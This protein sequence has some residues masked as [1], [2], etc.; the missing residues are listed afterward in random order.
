MGKGAKLG[1]MAVLMGFIGL[2]FFAALAREGEAPIA[3]LSP[4]EL[5]ALERE[6]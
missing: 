2:L 4:S 1:M 5:E 3:H 6:M